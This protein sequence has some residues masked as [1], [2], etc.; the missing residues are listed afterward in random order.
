MSHIVTVQN[1]VTDPTA[2]TAACRRQGLADPTQGTAKLY[3]G[4]VNGLLIQLPGWQYPVVIDTTT[5]TMQYDNYQGHWGETLHL[6]RFLQMYAVEKARLEA[7]R[8]GCTVTEQQ[9]QDGSIRLRITEG[10]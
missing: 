2:I 4:E 6:E 5:G 9:L 1:R 8:K 3:S 10:T 7:R